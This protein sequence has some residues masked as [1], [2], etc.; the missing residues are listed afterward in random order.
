MP[1]TLD[2]ILPEGVGGGGGGGGDKQPG[3]MLAL[4]V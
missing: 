3:S 1:A 4:R 2:F